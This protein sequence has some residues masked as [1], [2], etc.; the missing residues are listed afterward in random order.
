MAVVVVSGSGRGVGKTALVCGLIAALPEF[1]WTAV[2]VASHAHRLTGPIWEERVAGQGNDTARYLA[3]GAHR[4]ILVTA[5]ED[6][7]GRVVLQLIQEQGSGKHL[8]FESNRALRHLKPDLCL[9]VAGGPDAG[10]KPSFA[11]VV[12]R[13]DAMVAH[14]DRDHVIAGEPR[15]FQLAAFEHVSSEMLAWIRGRLAKRVALR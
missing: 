12:E 14:A 5:G 1:R 13:M 9:A 11:A 15:R 3:A 8:I 7:L 10:H 2:K 4:A 6:E